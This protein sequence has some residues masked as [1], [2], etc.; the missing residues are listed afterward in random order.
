M[1]CLKTRSHANTHYKVTFINRTRSILKLPSNSAYLIKVSEFKRSYLAQIS[2]IYADRPF[3][4]E[5]LLLSSRWS[6]PTWA[7]RDTR[8]LLPWRW[9]RGWSQNHCRTSSAL[10]EG[11]QSPPAATH[12]ESWFIRTFN[13]KHVVFHFL[14]TFMLYVFYSDLSGCVH[15]C[16]LCGRMCQNLD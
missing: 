11:G 13:I 5:A 4:F 8:W 9:G 10:T 3:V 2:Q 14:L 16:L 1:V 7:G 15:V 12:T 6:C